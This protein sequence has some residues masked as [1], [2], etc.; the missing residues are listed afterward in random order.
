MV[1]R[2]ATLELRAVMASLRK[3]MEQGDMSLLKT[4]RSA[5]PQHSFQC[6]YSAKAKDARRQQRTVAIK[7]KCAQ[8]KADSAE[9][10]AGTR[11][12]DDDAIGCVSD[13]VIGSFTDRRVL[14]LARSEEEMQPAA[15]S[16]GNMGGNRRLRTVR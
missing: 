13:S 14:N 8:E 12:D 4:D 2:A 11:D 7:R 10:E 15:A 5:R 9:Q 16:G 1:A 3:C 6:P